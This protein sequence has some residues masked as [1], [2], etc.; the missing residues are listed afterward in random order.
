MEKYRRS[1]Q[2]HRLLKVQDLESQCNSKLEV[3]EDTCPQ[4]L[5]KTI[6][7]LWNDPGVQQVYGLAHQFQLNETAKYVYAILSI[8]LSSDKIDANSA[9]VFIFFLS[10]IFA[11]RFFMPLFFFIQF[12]NF[13]NIAILTLL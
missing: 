13:R 9:H 7:N 1:Y 6:S 2:F 4:S 8:S 3:L 5:G 10:A 11:T 12:S